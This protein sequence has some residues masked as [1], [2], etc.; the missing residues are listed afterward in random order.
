MVVEAI[1]KYLPGRRPALG[2]GSLSLL[3]LQTGFS[4]VEV[5]RKY[6]WF[7][8]RE[9]LFDEEAV[10]DMAALKAS[11]GL[12]DEQASAERHAGG[13]VV[14]VGQGS[15]LTS[16]CRPLVFVPVTLEQRSRWVHEE[17]L[18]PS[19]S[20]LAGRLRAD[21]GPP[22]GCPA[23]GGGTAGACAARVRAV[24]HRDGQP[25]GHVAGASH[26]DRPPGSC[27]EANRVAARAPAWLELTQPR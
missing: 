9:R 23:G 11:L 25:G 13:G 22:P 7:L 2:P 16:A 5:F 1:S 15:Q 14:R 19:V 4:G 27:L 6:L 18:E 24:R 20:L 12:T 3:K 26:T 10:A 21:V 8:L 17:G